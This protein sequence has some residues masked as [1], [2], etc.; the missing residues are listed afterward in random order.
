MITELE[1]QVI[2]LVKNTIV[3]GINYHEGSYSAKE[4]I[5]ELLQK[6]EVALHTEAIDKLVEWLK[7]SKL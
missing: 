3:A 1:K 2:R 7:Q 5:E 6:S 4:A